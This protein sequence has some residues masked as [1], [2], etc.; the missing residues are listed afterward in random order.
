MAM[1]IAKNRTSG[2][3]MRIIMRSNASAKRHADALLLDELGE[4]PRDRLRRFTSD[5]A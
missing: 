1:T 4:L 5:D 2:S 3:G